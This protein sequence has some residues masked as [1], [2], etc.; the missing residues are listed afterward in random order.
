M[1]PDFLIIGGM[2]CGS[3]SLLH[4]LR[5]H[6]DILLPIGIKNLAFYD[7]RENWS[8]GLAWYESFFQNPNSKSQVVGEISTE[9]TKYPDTKNVAVNMASIVPDAKLI[10]LIRHP[11]ERLQSHYIH[12]VGEGKENR[13]INKAL[14]IFE[15]NRYI[16][17]SRYHLQLEQFLPFYDAANILIV[18]SESLRKNR[19]ATLTRVFDFVGVDSSYKTIP[20]VSLNTASERKKWNIF[21]LRLKKS[22]RYFNYYNYYRNK[23]PKLTGI[24]DLALCSSIKVDKISEK[25]KNKLTVLF[26]NDIENLQEKF[27][28]NLSHWKAL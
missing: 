15:N 17:Y 6:S 1:L 4:Y 18:T 20:E 11:I 23:Y 25:T 28:V 8:E 10:Y 26:K 3:T 22:Q 2:K 13:C 9:Y 19:N 12:M 14:E 7:E 24:T 27:D 5:S 16:N 21:G